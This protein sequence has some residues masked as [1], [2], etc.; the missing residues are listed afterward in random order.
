[1][2]SA[3]SLI[4]FDYPPPLCS[5]PRPKQPL[6]RSILTTEQRAY[7]KKKAIS[8]NDLNWASHLHIRTP[9]CFILFNVPLLIYR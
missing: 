7:R 9:T 5:R 4:G 8:E 1:M 2:P 6:F 3:W